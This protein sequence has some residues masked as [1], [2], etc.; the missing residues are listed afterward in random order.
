MEIKEPNSNSTLKF[1]ENGDLEYSGNVIALGD[2][3]SENLKTIEKKLNK[4]IEDLTKL[5][6]KLEG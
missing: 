5:K 3:S 4:V 6:I 1:K 2:I